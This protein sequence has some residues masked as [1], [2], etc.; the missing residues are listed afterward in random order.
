MTDEL[1]YVVKTKDGRV[2]QGWLGRDLKK[3]YV[4]GW[5]YP[6]FEVY[7]EP[8]KKMILVKPEEILA[9]DADQELHRPIHP[10]SRADEDLV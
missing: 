4:E 6:A 8:G 7:N 9:V 3:F 5:S 1:W 10:S 2:Y